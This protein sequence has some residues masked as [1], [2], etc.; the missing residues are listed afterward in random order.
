MNVLVTGSTGFLG[1]HLCPL[2]IKNGYTVRCLTSKECDLTHSDSL[3]KL[4]NTKYDQIYHLAAYT[5]AGDFCLH[6]GGDQWVINQLVNTHVLDWW[7]K[8]QPQAKLIAFGTSVSYTSEKDLSEENYMQGIPNDK[9]FAYAMS[10]RM[11]YAG[12]I[13][14]NKQF[15]LKYL[16]LVP[17]TLYGPNY[18]TDG[19]QLHF[20]YDLIRKILR[21]KINGEPV[22]LWGDGFQ[23]RELVYID[24]FVR[25]MLRLVETKENDIINIGAGE[26]YTIRYFAQLICDIIGYDFRAI[27]FDE[28]KYVG[29]KSKC[30]E[31][32]KVRRMIPDL[33]MTPLHIGLSKT[34]DWLKTQRSIL[35]E[36]R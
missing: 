1:R 12:L 27:I 13:S 18:H 7:Q 36:E 24:D 25:I 30:L 15:D 26:E 29:A 10:K 8:Y 28:S 9:F 31:T 20:I 4:L 16:Y 14:L 21:G 17:S 32:E 23:K 33:E 34:I 5:Q 6:H 22:V 3:E 11:L 19:R 35:I 2:L